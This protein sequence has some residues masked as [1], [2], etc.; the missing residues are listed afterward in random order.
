MH[1]EPAVGF[2]RLLPHNSARSHVIFQPTLVRGLPGILSI[3]LLVQVPACFCVYTA[4][5]LVLRTVYVVKEGRLLY[6][7]N[8]RPYSY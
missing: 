3:E 7:S 1:D 8:T 4:S 5:I 2:R 6:S